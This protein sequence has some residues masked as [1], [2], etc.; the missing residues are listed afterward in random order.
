MAV[1]VPVTNLEDVVSL[2][3]FLYRA[4]SS[5]DTNDE[6]SIASFGPSLAAL[7]NNRGAFADFF[8]SELLKVVRDNVTFGGARAIHS[9]QTFVIAR[10][11]GYYIRVAL[12][13]LPKI[14]NGSTSWDEDFYSYG[15]AHNHSFSLLTTGL[16]G[17]GYVSENY[18]L[19]IKPTMLKSGDEVEICKEADQTL[20]SGIVLLY[21]KWSDIHIQHPCS[22]FSMSL[23]LMVNDRSIPQ[24]SFDVRNGRV[25]NLIAGRNFSLS[26]A[27]SLANSF[28][29][30]CGEDLLR[31][32]KI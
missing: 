25:A 11:P 28:S 4:D 12:W 15:Y 19:K 10:R 26:T 5:L 32:I 8:E 27:L 18:S 6:R 21:R 23:N 9:E 7:A 13:D 3:E 24:Y 20:S 2:E 30:E 16:F 14:R 17:P 1:Q 29:T 31:N 22:S